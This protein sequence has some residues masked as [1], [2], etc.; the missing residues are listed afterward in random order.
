MTIVKIKHR[1]VLLLIGVPK[2]FWPKKIV[3]KI[4][5]VDS[6]RENQIS[7]EYFCVQSMSKSC[8]I[9]QSHLR[10]KMTFKLTLNQYSIRRI[11]NSLKQL[12]SFFLNIIVNVFVN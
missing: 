4:K 2:D 5:L 7:N 12:L 6:E 9:F 11:G 1:T 8:A 10:L 3:L